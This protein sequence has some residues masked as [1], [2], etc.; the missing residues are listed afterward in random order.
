M[1]TKICWFKHDA[2]PQK[3]VPTIL[4]H[5]QECDTEFTEHGN[6]KWNLPNLQGKATRKRDKGDV[7]W[8][9]I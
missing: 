4:M 6:L 7:L 5:I 2:K 1:Q 8:H 3:D 9:L